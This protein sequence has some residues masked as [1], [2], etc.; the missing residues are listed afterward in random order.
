MSLFWPFLTFSQLFHNKIGTYCLQV[1]IFNKGFYILSVQSMFQLY[2]APKNWKGQLE[3]SKQST[4][5]INTLV[6]F[7]HWI[8]I[9][10]HQ[11]P[12]NNSYSAYA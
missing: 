10:W 2:N 6:H 11:T 8:C 1:F 3:N 7:Q 9:K 12:Y 4:P 5:A